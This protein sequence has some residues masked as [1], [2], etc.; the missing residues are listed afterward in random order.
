M[1][2]TQGIQLSVFLSIDNLQA[3]PGVPKLKEGLNPATWMLQIST[4]GM[5]K[6]IGIDF[7]DAYKQSE[8]FRYSC[9]LNQHSLIDSGLSASSS[10]CLFQ[11]S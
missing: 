7:A 6:S 8:V 1:T 2:Q 10:L 11:A 4:P 9:L 5:E 3:L